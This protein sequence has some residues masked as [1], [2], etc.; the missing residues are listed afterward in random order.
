MSRYE[1][2]VVFEGNKAYVII[3]FLASDCIG[4]LWTEQKHLVMT[5][6]AFIEC[7]DKWIK[8]REE[9]EE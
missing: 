7:Y 4:T 6:E 5:K 2:E 8:P 1:E 3:P 9:S